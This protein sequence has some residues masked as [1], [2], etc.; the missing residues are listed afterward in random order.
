MSLMACNKYWRMCCL[1]SCGLCSC[2]LVLFIP[3]ESEVM[4]KS[5]C[6]YTLVTCV[7]SCSG[8]VILFIPSHSCPW[9]ATPFPCE[10]GSDREFHNCRNRQSCSTCTCCCACAVVV[11]GAVDVPSRKPG[12]K[13]ATLHHRPRPVQCTEST[14]S[15]QVS[16]RIHLDGLS[17]LVGGDLR[18]YFE[19]VP[20]HN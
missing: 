19:G 1:C 6:L 12:A 4:V 13:L 11:A 10:P 17:H 7:G 18:R 2:S 9:V 5:D 14:A 20:G 16:K 3:L 15:L 8:L